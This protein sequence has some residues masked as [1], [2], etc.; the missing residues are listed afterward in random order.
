[1]TEAPEP[2]KAASPPNGQT[3]PLQLYRVSIECKAS[4]G[5][6]VEAEVRARAN[7]DGMNLRR[8]SIDL[9][10]AGQRLSIVVYIACRLSARAVLAALVRWLPHDPDVLNVCWES[11]P[12]PDE[13]LG[14]S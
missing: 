7:A 4:S 8:L 11:L 2:H 10:V 3:D 5:T 14:R 9:D 6:R 12:H 13:H 1:M